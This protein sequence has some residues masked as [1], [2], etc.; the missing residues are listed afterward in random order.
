MP[1]VGFRDREFAEV[2]VAKPESLI[3]VVAESICRV[4]LAEL[5]V[6]ALEPPDETLT[7]AVPVK[8]PPVPTN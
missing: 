4:P 5:R 1:D 7:S 8:V 2:I 3:A 6:S